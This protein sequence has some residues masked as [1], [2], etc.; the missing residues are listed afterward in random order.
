MK[1]WKWSPPVK[2]DFMRTPRF[3][4]KDNDLEKEKDKSPAQML[5]QLDDWSSINPDISSLEGD[6]KTGNMRELVEIKVGLSYLSSLY[7]AIEE[8]HKK[9]KAIIIK[10]CSQFSA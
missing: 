1:E 7:Q 2:E 8:V 6:F 5:S 9:I 3:L 4:K 10:K